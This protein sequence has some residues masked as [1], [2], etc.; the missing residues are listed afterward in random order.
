MVNRIEKALISL[1]AVSILLTF[2]SATEAVNTYEVLPVDTMELVDC[3]I[4]SGSVTSKYF[5]MKIIHM[6]V[7]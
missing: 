3:E 6:F 1:L 4:V 2:S 7:L 5:L